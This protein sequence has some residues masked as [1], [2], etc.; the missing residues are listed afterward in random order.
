LSAADEAT[1]RLSRNNG[2][3]TAERNELEAAAPGERQSVPFKE[4]AMTVRSRLAN[5]ML[6]VQARTG[7]VVDGELP[8]SDQSIVDQFQVFIDAINIVRQA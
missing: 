5:V 7:L 1:S 3:H 2:P 4:E 6:D 8:T